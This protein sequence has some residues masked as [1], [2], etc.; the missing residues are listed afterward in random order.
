MTAN[1]WFA[2]LRCPNGGDNQVTKPLSQTRVPKPSNA[3]FESS[4]LPPLERPHQTW[5]RRPLSTCAPID[6]HSQLGL[7]ISGQRPLVVGGRWRR[8]R[9]SFA[10]ARRTIQYTQWIPLVPSLC[11]LSLLIGAA[12]DRP[13]RPQNRIAVYH[14]RACIYWHETCIPVHLLC[15][16]PSNMF[17]VFGRTRSLGALHSTCF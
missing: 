8:R 17:H 16:L 15:L 13:H 7:R 5:R 12:F 11:S 2:E 6:A 14:L 4:L 9:D 10:V 1:Y 3:C